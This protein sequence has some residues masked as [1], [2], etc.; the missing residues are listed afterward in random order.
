MTDR[1]TNQQMDRP[2]KNVTWP[3]DTPCSRDVCPRLNK[4]MLIWPWLFLNNLKFELLMNGFVHWVDLNHN[5]EQTFYDHE[6]TLISHVQQYF[7]TCGWLVVCFRVR[8]KGKNF[9]IL[10]YG[11]L[12]AVRIMC[13]RVP[14]RAKIGSSRN[15]VERALARLS[16]WSGTTIRVRLKFVLN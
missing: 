12:G 8:L 11:K 1:P 14:K 6:W 10:F 15:S 4:T 3:T 5:W 7:T 9:Q 13:G 16:I 2:T